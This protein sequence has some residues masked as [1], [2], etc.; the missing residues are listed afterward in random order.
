MRKLRL[1]TVADVVLILAS[2]T[3]LT[4]YGLPLVRAARSRPP[5][6]YKV[7]DQLAG[8]ERLSLKGPTFVLFTNSRCGFCVASMP[9]YAKMVEK[10]ARVIATT[11][12]DLEV[13]KA[14]LSAHGVTPESVRPIAAMGLKF[15]GTPS[16]LYVDA[17][18]IVRG[19]W[20]GKQSPEGEKE[21][22][23]KLESR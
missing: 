15:A 6:V 11:A 2:L 9:L 1:A 19:V 5:A 13:H 4:T 3:V 20:L 21:I 22:L 18:G 10:G 23:E 17:A 7:G 12:E 16:L 8:A 14:F